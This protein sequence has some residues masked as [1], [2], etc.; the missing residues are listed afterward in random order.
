MQHFMNALTSER[1][2]TAIPEEYD[3]FGKLIGI[4]LEARRQGNMIVLSNLEDKSRKWLFAKIEKNNF[5][6]QDLTVKNDGQRYVN[7]TYMPSAFHNK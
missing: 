5:H 2:N 4:Q 7:F 1:K 6:W 3:F